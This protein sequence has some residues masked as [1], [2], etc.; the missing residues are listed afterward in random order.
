M[1]EIYFHASFLSH[2]LIFRNYVRFEQ[3]LLFELHDNIF[4]INYR[5]NKNATVLL[6]DC[7]FT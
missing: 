4:V 7:Y 6:R 5:I 2:M 1:D 3:E